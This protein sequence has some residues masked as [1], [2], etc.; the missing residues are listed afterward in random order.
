MYNIVHVPL[1]LMKSLTQCSISLIGIRRAG[2]RESLIISHCTKNFDQLVDNIRP[3]TGTYI[4][5]TARLKKSSGKLIDECKLQ[6]DLKCSDIAS[7][8][9]L[10]CNP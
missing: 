2:R 1:E 10:G 6:N 5:N 4:A 3:L 8:C 9:W 7:S